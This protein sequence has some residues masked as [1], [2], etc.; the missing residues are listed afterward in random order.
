MRSITVVL[1]KKKM[2]SFCL[3]FNRKMPLSVKRE[4]LLFFLPL[5]NVSS[6]SKYNLIFPHG[7]SSRLYVINMSALVLKIIFGRISYSVKLKYVEIYLK[8]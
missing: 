6:E 1:F 5:L 7:K 4:L 3:G 8:N 2:P